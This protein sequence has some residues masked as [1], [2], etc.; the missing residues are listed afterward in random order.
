M[1]IS[2]AYRASKLGPDYADCVP[3]AQ[4]LIA[5]NADRIV[6]G[7]D[8]PHPNSVTPADKKVTDVTPLFQIDDGRLLEPASGVGAGRGDPQEDSGRQP[9]AAL[10]V[11]KP[12]ARHRGPLLSERVAVVVAQPVAGLAQAA[13]REQVKSRDRRRRGRRRA[14]QSPDDSS[15]PVSVSRRP[16]RPIWARSAR[17]ELPMPQRSANF[18]NVAGV[19]GP[20]R[21]TMT[22]R[23]MPARSS[24]ADPLQDR[25]ALEAE[26]RDDIDS[27]FS[28]AVPS[29][30]NR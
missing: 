4:S 25:G 5:A 23:S 24:A 7:T 17:M 3:L 28:S 29:R 11:L 12:G 2:G 14:A 18:V 16:N 9:G 22:G 6:W 21:P 15:G 13:E 19:A 27:V 1:K 20:A 10:R 26:L 30:A 8:W